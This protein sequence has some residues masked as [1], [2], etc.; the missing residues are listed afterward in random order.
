VYFWG[1]AIRGILWKLEMFFFVGEG[2]GGNLLDSS[3]WPLTSSSHLHECL[4]LLFSNTT[5]VPLAKLKI[6]VD[7]AIFL[8]QFLIRTVVK[9][10]TYLSKY[11]DTNIQRYW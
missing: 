6:L 1:N 5:F 3:K 8:L 2:E 7:V 10:Y 4:L 9:T 11:L